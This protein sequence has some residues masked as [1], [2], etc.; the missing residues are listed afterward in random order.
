MGYIELIIIASIIL[1]VG[2]LVRRYKTSR[3]EVLPH[4]RNTCIE[5]KCFIAGSTSLQVERDALR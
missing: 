3:K 2:V 4:K 1:A 5:Y